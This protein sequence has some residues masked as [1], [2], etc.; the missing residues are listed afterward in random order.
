MSEAGKG[1][2][3]RRARRRVLYVNEVDLR[4]SDQGIPTSLEERVSDQ[5]RQDAAD[6]AH[7]VG[8][9]DQS[10]TQRLKENVPPHAQAR[11]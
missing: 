8:E 1:S 9:A 6:K 5:E 10:N 3:R 2:V 4:L 7:I 11:I